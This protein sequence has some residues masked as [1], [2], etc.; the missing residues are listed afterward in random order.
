MECLDFIK[1]HG[2]Y[3]NSHRYCNDCDLDKQYDT[4]YEWF[5]NSPKEVIEIVEN[6]IKENPIETNRQK[7][8]QMY[9]DKPWRN[10]SGVGA[11]HST[12]KLS[13]CILN[14]PCHYCDWWEE[15]FKED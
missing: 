7:L 15:E 8:Q 10:F 2:R 11:C 9:P 14:T 4:C 3:C 1:L 6:W 13:L 12:S 5:F